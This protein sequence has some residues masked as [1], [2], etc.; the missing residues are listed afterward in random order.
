MAEPVPDARTFTEVWAHRGEHR[1]RVRDY[2]GAEPA[3]VLMRGFPDN[4]QLYDRLLPH[5]GAFRR[6]VTFDF[7]AGVAR[8]SRPAA[9]TPRTTRPA[10]WIAAPRPA[11][12][13]LRVDAAAAT[14]GGDH[15][16]LHTGR[17]K[18]RPPGDAQIRATRP[19]AVR[20]AGRPVRPRRRRQARS[21][22]RAVRGFSGRAPG[23]LRLNADL[24]PILLSRR[25]KRRRLRAFPR[26]VRI[27]FGAADP[28]LNTSVARTFHRL[29]PRS[30]LLPGARHYV[31]IDEPEHVARLILIRTVRGAMA[32]GQR[33][34]GAVRGPRTR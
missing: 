24:L 33:Y 19:A 32:D 13:L 6:V 8:T 25:R 18:P 2:P 17:P 23:L 16:V 1:I 4:P 29:F 11:Q 27:V 31:Q 9:R 28:Y 7:L 3:I 34:V 20:L 22:S 21:H 10:T 15:P 12:H 14:A 26:P 5:L 30:E